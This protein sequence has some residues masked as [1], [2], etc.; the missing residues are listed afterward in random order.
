MRHKGIFKGIITT[1]VLVIFTML[2]VVNTYAK[3]Q[4]IGVPS[5]KKMTIQ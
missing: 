1:G 2:G 4:S 3:E 5:M